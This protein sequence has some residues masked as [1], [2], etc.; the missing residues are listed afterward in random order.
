[1]A[2]PADLLVDTQTT[3]ASSEMGDK[4]DLAPITIAPTVKQ[5]Q[6]VIPEPFEISF[7]Q[8]HIINDTEQN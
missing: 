2:R 5:P 1:M 3:I 6:N 7:D 8:G 4:K